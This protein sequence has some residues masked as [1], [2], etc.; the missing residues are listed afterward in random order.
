LALRPNAREYW[1]DYAAVLLLRGEQ[2]LYRQ[3]CAELVA[4]LKTEDPRTAYLRARVCG[5]APEAV[6]DLQLPIQLAE[7][8]VAADGKVGWYLHTLAMA[9]YRAGQYTEALHWFHASMDQDLAWAARPVNWLGMALT[10]HGQGQNGEARLW[11]DKA[12]LWMD[13]KAPQLRN[14]PQ[15]VFVLHPHDWLACLILRAEAEELLEN[16]PA[17]TV[18]K[19]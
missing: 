1:L 5:L 16:D 14:H 11:L 2:E 7:R 8:A 18:G 19:E 12:A 6:S 10:Y 3:L 15:G 17:Q 9:H 4:P 13:E